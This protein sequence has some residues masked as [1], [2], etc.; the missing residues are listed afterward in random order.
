MISAISSSISFP[1]TH[2]D[3]LLI[4]QVQ[5]LIELD[6]SVLVLLEGSG[7][8]L[9]GSFLAGGEIGHDLCVQKE[10]AR[11]EVGSV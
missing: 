6:T 3:Q 10:D 9:G 1:N 2:L 11:E 7:C 4:V 5:E 8:L